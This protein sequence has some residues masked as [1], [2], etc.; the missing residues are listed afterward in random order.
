MVSILFLIVVAGLLVGV[1]KWERIASSYQR[2]KR[3]KY[4][5]W[6]ID[7]AT[8]VTIN[9]GSKLKERMSSSYEEQR[10]R[11]SNIL[12]DINNP[13]IHD[14]VKRTRIKEFYEQENNKDA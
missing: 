5:V 14:E 12:N 3:N 1:W 2:W 9:G 10:Y 7:N 11:L 4:Y 6:L 13:S 8:E